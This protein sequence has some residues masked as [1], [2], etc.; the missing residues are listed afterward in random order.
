MSNLLAI[1]DL[2][3]PYEHPDSWDFLAALKAYYRPSVVVQVGDIVDMHHQSFHDK[4]P[5]ALGA[6][7]EF[8]QAKVRMKRF[9]R[10]FPGAH[11]TL[12]NH[13][14]RPERIAQ[15]FGLLPD[16]LKA[17]GDLWGTPSLQFS[18]SYVHRLEDGS[19][20]HISHGDKALP[21][22]LSS[23]RK[24]AN[25]T[26]CGHRHLEAGIRWY[27]MPDSTL[28]WAGQTGCLVDMDSPAFAYTPFERALL[29]SI[30]VE[31]DVPLFIPMHLDKH[32]RWTGSF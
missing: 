30:V 24:L 1:G 11:I 8:E 26:I 21:T 5:E 10:M 7:E 14:I 31:G 29:G 22:F 2:H 23:G 4:H 15:K 19:T 16:M 32:K 3:Y 25:H 28:R 12:G 13:G 9:E 20:L 18:K 6:R 27:V 17:K